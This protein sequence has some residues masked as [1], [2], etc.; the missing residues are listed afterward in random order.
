MEIAYITEKHEQQ[1]YFNHREQAI[2]LKKKIQAFQIN[3]IAAKTIYTDLEDSR[4]VP[5]L[6]AAF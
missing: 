5:H 6:L 2:S 1:S 4:K 3:W